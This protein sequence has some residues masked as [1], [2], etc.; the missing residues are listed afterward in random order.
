[1]WIFAPAHAVRCRS[2]HVQTRTTPTDQKILNYSA[3]NDEIQDFEANIRNVSG[4]A[5]D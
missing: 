1:V 5:G 3:I 2:T 4:G